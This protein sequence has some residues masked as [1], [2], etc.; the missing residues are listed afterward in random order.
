MT[1]YTHDDCNFDHENGAATIEFN[2][3]KISPR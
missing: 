1:E 2:K 3:T